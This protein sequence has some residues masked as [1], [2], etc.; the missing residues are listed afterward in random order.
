MFYGGESNVPG[1]PG[2]FGNAGDLAVHPQPI[3]QRT[4]DLMNLQQQNPE[5]YKKLIEEKKVEGFAQPGG[6]PGMPGNSMGMQ[7]ANVPNFGVNTIG[8]GHRDAMRG[9]KINNL[10]RSNTNASEVEAARNMLRG[11]SLPTF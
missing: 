4:R 3:D 6:I 5:L 9:A 8:P 11:P 1:A 2:N 7:I 10:T